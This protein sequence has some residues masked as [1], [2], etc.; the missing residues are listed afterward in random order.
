[1]GSFD[2]QYNSETKVEN[3][4]TPML[5]DIGILLIISAVFL[6]IGLVGGGFELSAIKFPMVDKPIRFAMSGIGGV[7][8]IVALIRL[9]YPP[10]V[11]ED[12]RATPAPVVDAGSTPTTMSVPTMLPSTEVAPTAVLPTQAPPMTPEPASFAK[13]MAQVF[14]L[15]VPNGKIVEV[16]SATQTPIL[17]D[18][19]GSGRAGSVGLKSNLRNFILHTTMQIGDAD[20][21]CQ[22]YFRTNATG[23]Y[24]VGIKSTGGVLFDLKNGDQYTSEE[25]PP[26]TI[27]PGVNDIVLVATD[28]TYT[29]YI[30]GVQIPGDPFTDNTYATGGLGLVAWSPSGINADETP[31]CVFSDIWVWERDE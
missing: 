26:V 6:L 22:I 8:L 7:L 18:A 20:D 10:T 5:G 12:E 1:L 15:N 4:G 30:N 31:S 29:V 27:A 3:E 14:G 16:E 25:S 23:A 21:V 11:T 9:L 13:V 19:Y 24:N 17:K 2:L 28:D